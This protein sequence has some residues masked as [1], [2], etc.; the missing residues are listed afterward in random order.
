[1]MLRRSEGVVQCDRVGRQMV[2]TRKSKSGSE[3]ENM[4]AHKYSHRIAMLLSAEN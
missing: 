4:R 1:M 3:E 2:T